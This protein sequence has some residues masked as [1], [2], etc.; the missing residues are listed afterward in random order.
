MKK[1]KFSILL[2]TKNRLQ[3]LKSCIN[4]VLEQNFNDFE[5][6]VSDN[7]SKDNTQK[8]CKSIFDSRLK[9]F[10]L[11]QDHPVTFNWNNAYSKARGEYIIII[12]DDDYLTKNYLAKVNEQI[13][14]Q[15]EEII[16]VNQARYHHQ[17]YEDLNFRNK[18][19]LRKYSNK[20]FKIKSSK[21]LSDFF[22]FIKTFHSASITIKKSISDTIIDSGEFG[23][24]KEPFPDYTAIFRAIS[25]VDHISY[26]DSPLLIAGVS[27]MGCGIQAQTDRK[28]YWNDEVSTKFSVVPPISGDFFINYYYISQKIVQSKIKTMFLNQTSKDIWNY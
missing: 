16:I 13:S 17:D 3:L 23:P 26:I 9:Y 19:I 22:N 2:P 11:N 27:S 18:L 4:S 28:K 25:L 5:L 24:Y 7:N 6:I 10:R 21:Y 1:P 15:A 8:Y 14:N 12:G 20:T